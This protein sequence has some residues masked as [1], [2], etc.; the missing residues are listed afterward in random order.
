M[1]HGT[2]KEGL[3]KTS[4]LNGD[5][6]GAYR[7]TTFPSLS[8][9]NL[10]KFHFIPSPKR[11]P[12]LDFK[13]LQRGAALPPLTSTYITELPLS[14]KDTKKQLD[15]L[16][17]NLDESSLLTRE[18]KFEKVLKKHEDLVKYGKLCFKASAGHFCNLLIITWFLSTKLIAWESQY[19]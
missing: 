12:L 2:K 11:P 9:R 19:F 4:I 17:I 15:G 3:P 14:P 8:T 6:V 13:N 7:S 16:V 10:V 1:I 5:V 18:K